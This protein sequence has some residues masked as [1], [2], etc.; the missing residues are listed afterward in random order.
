[1]RYGEFV[2][3]ATSF[4]SLP[5]KGMTEVALVFHTTETSG[6]PGFK[7]G[8]TAPHF[9]YEPKNGAWSQMAELNRRVG[10]MK[11][12]ATT[13]VF[14]NEKSIQVEI[15][16][17][18]SRKLADGHPARLW[19]GDFSDRM[20][21]DLARFVKW[22]LDNKMISNRVYGPDQF[23]SF[24]GANS[25]H[26]LTK[27]AWYSFDGLTAH[28]APPGQ[29]HFDTGALNLV[30]IMTEA[31]GGQLPPQGD[32]MAFLPLIKTDGFEAGRVDRIEDVKALQARLNRIA[33]VSPKVT[34]DGKYGDDTATAIR[35][36][37]SGDAV[38]N[39]ERCTGE[40]YEAISFL[41]LGGR[42]GIEAE[43]LA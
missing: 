23:T 3:G 42:N 22:C 1:V 33:N 19:V 7:S 29:T 12:S 30:R 6:M 2:G 31:T 14:A 40:V 10:T 39:G 4:G 34:V 16:G 15:I 38:E 9:V 28:G 36:A 13:K 11:G 25:K 26:R 24:G 32:D 35:Q 21:T 37:L 20:Y 43:A 17:Y 18:S 8:K 27:E 41:A 5:D